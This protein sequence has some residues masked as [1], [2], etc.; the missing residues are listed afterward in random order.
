MALCNRVVVAGVIA[1]TMA[2]M[3]TT[4]II[5]SSGVDSLECPTDLVYPYWSTCF[6]PAKYYGREVYELGDTTDG[7]LA[8]EWD[9]SNSTYY[10]RL[11]EEGAKYLFTH[12]TRE[13]RFAVSQF[14]NLLIKNVDTG[15]YLGWR[16]EGE[17][18]FFLVEG[19]GFTFFSFSKVEGV[20]LLCPR[21]ANARCE[22]YY[23]VDS[24]YPSM[25]LT[26]YV[27]DGVTYFKR[28]NISNATPFLL[29]RSD[30]TTTVQAI[31]MP[32]I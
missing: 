9:E 7:N 24:G 6:S 30:T 3:M 13:Y 20:S 14:D 18:E 32:T 26:P 17:D 23:I 12:L 22:A 28:S 31:E 10:M 27:E 21:M 29:L 5:T 4:M 2:A 16:Q 8:P 1:T 25:G 11:A 19:D 15:R